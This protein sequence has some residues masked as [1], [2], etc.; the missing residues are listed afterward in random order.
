L[1]AGIE[2]SIRDLVQK[3]AGTV[4]FTGRIDWDPSKPNGQPRRKLDTTR[5]EQRFGFHHA[6]GFEKGL[7]HT[8]EWY[9]E[10]IGNGASVRA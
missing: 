1:G 10:S 2:V 9:L 5:A 4:G 8:V 3:I 6:I 7:R